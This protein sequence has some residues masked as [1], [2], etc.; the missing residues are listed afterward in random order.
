MITYRN[1][2][3]PLFDVFDA[4]NNAVSVGSRD[5]STVAPQ[6]L[7]LLNHPIVWSQAQKLAERVL[8]ESKAEESAQVD[9]LWRLALGRAP[10]ESER[11]TAI[12]QLQSSEPG[13]RATTLS[14]LSLAVFNHN[15]FVF[16]D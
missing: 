5:S 7:W 13:A 12:A 10:T 14:Q 2:R 3:F 4:P 8:R 1:F 15:E 11:Q 16:I 9:R 6:T